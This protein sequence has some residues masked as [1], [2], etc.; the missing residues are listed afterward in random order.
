M[1]T[2][3]LCAEITWGKGC[4]P[5]STAVL[6]LMT[7]MRQFPRITA[8]IMLGNMYLNKIDSY[9]DPSLKGKGL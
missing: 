7:S 3:Q 4:V 5:R 8:G 9:M 1:V 6:R 2:S